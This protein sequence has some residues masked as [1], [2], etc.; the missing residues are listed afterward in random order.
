V[1][2]LW[3]AL[4]GVG[5]SVVGGAVGGWFVLLAAHRQS[6][7]DRQSARLDR[8]HQ[9]ALAIADAI[10]ALA[11]AVTT[12]KK[13]QDHDLVALATAFNA[14]S[15]AVS[16][17]SIA[18]IDPDLRNRVRNQTQLTI[19]FLTLLAKEELRHRNWPIQYSSTRAHCLKHLTHT[20]TATH[21]PPTDLQTWRPVPDCSVQDWSNV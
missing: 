19:A 12:W 20:L 14:Y 3:A 4:I 7:H 10:A 16:V 15:Q 1:A 17:Q 5:G 6:E 13:R 21:C 9:A 2:W 11:V 8:S 18:L